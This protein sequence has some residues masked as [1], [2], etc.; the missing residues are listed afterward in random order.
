MPEYAG[1]VQ[2]EIRY[3]EWRNIDRQKQGVRKR[4]EEK[5]CEY[6]LF[7]RNNGERGECK[8]NWWWVLN[9]ISGHSSTECGVGVTVDEE[10]EGRMIE[11]VKKS[12]RV[13]VGLED[14]VLNIVSAYA[15]HVGCAKRMSFCRRKMW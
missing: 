13:K 10:T 5:K 8:G 14:K 9:H 2:C 1:Y 7:A 11:V 3:V 4:F 15:Q 6:F 12:D